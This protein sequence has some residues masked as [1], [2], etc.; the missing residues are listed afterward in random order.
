MSNERAGEVTGGIWL[1]GLGIL[2]Y[3][4]MWWPGIMFVIGVSAIAQGL[5]E[6]RGWYSFQGGLWSI[7]IGIWAYYKFN[8]A[9]F[10]VALGVSMVVMA[11]ARPPMFEKPKPFTDNTL[12]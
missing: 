1:I 4:G 3:T 6:G 11:L 10:F 2:F 9:I 12:E 7:A 5:V 8:M